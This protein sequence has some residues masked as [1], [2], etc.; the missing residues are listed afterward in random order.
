MRASS[1]DLISFLSFLYIFPCFSL[2]SFVGSVQILIYASC[3]GMSIIGL[4]CCD[5]HLLLSAIKTSRA[6]RFYGQLSFKFHFSGARIE[7]TKEKN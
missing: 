2:S 4:G 7:R 1:F 3:Q 6:F 5:C